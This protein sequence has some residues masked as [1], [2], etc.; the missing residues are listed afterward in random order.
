MK[1]YKFEVNYI[2][3]DKVASRTNY[4]TQADN[5]SDA[6][7]ALQKEFSDR[8]ILYFNLKT[9]TKSVDGKTA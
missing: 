5:L 7:K 3:H 2:G 6:I 4:I 9:I 1:R 8:V